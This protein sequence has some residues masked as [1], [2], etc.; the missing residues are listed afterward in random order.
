MAA[1]AAEVGA[2]DVG[3]A[4]VGAAEVGAA[5]VGAAEEVAGL[6]AEDVGAGVGEGDEQ[7]NVRVMISDKHINNQRNR[8]IF[9]F[10]LLKFSY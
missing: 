2:A 6:G 9:I 3:A 4:D 8:I 5:D 10:S 7:A 1:G